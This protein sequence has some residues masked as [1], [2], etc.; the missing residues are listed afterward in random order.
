MAR[1]TAGHIAELTRL[2]EALLELEASEE[3]THGFPLLDALSTDTAK[4]GD[5]IEAL[6]TL[7]GRDD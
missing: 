4:L 2:C 7:V 6:K 5:C 3:R 1:W